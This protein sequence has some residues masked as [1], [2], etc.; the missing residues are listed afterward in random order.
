VALTAYDNITLEDLPVKVRN[1]HP[2]QLVSSS[3]DPADLITL[4]ELE[5]RYVTRVL[6]TLGDNKTQA[7]KILGIER[8][9]LYR[10]LE[11]HEN[12]GFNGHG[13]A[14]GGSSETSDAGD[15]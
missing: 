9:T 5:R 11:R 4:A 12:G 3:S 1:H 14:L 13:R 7:A 6:K 15:L 8:R 10:K 2:D